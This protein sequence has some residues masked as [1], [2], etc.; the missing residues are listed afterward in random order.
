MAK[1]LSILKE[2]EE[3]RSW[4]TVYFVLTADHLEE[5]SNWKKKKIANNQKN[6]RTQNNKWWGRKT[7]SLQ[8]F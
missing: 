7:K 6:S 5:L 8:R 2:A 1:S 4:H 3:N